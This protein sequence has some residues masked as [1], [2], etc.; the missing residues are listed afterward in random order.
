M[1]FQNDGLIHS[2]LHS[3]L[4]PVHCPHNRLNN[5][6]KV[7][8]IRLVL[9]CNSFSGSSGPLGE[10]ANKQ[11]FDTVHKALHDLAPAI[12][13]NLIG[14]I[15]SSLTGP[16]PHSPY[17]GHTYQVHQIASCLRTFAH[18][19]FIIERLCPSPTPYHW[20]L[21]LC[22]N[23]TFSQTLLWPLLL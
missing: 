18:A 1:G 17:F 10:N 11:N 12:L 21:R 4:V 19:I 6:F 7:D 3:Y 22:W 2:C 8:F 15:F 14:T 20:F 9:C 16:E 23:T 5:Y 13:F